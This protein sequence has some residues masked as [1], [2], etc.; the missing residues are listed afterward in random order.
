MIG[1]VDGSLMIKSKQLEEF[2]Q[3]YDDE[4]KMIMDAFKPSFKST[5]KSYKYFYRGQYGIMPD[6][7]DIIAG[8]NSKK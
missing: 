4:M 2:K 5:S 7:E 6:P 8:M 3:E 1:L